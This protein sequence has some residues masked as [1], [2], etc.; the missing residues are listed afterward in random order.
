MEGLSGSYLDW[1]RV[2]CILTHPLP[3]LA[4]CELYSHTSASVIAC[5]WV[6]FSQIHFRVWLQ[7]SCTLTNPLLWLAACDSYSYKSTSLIGCMRFVLSHLAF[8]VT[9]WWVVLS[10]IHFRVWLHVRCTLTNPPPWLAVC[11]FYSHKSP[12]LIGCV[13][14][15]RFDWLVGSLNTSVSDTMRW[16]GLVFNSARRFQLFWRR[17]HTVKKTGSFFITVWLRV[18][19]GH[20][21]PVFLFWTVR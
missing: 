3:W 18:T 16:K 17:L 6:V 4:A 13:G 20:R 10:Q 9:G 5:M 12:S 1:L 7:V 8:S 11:A 2:N 14:G 15:A 21:K 19:H